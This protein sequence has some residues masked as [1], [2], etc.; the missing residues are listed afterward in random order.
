[1]SEISLPVVAIPAEVRA[2]GKDAV[3][4]YRAAVGF[5]QML[6]RRLTASLAEMASPDDAEES[7]AASSAYAELLPDALATQL[8]ANGGIGLAR[9]LYRGM[10]PAGSGDAV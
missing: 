1:M 10:Y 9:E 5:E 2:A 8:T 3:A 4:T 6:L 7:S